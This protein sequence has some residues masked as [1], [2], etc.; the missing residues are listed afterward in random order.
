MSSLRGFSIFVE[1]YCYTTKVT[2]LIIW[3]SSF[4]LVK[5]CNC[6][7]CLTLEYVFLPAVSS[8]CLCLF[9]P[10][11]WWLAWAPSFF[12][13]RPSTCI[14]SMHHRISFIPFN[15]WIIFHCVDI[16]GSHLIC[17]SGAGYYG[18]FEFVT[19]VDKAA[20]YPCERVLDGRAV[21]TGVGTMDSH[22]N[23][24]CNI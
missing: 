5:M 13:Y 6:F 23:S 4:L 18:C 21:S 15:G 8:H 16:L 12:L 1:T 9:P 2:H 17:S 20:V 11:H 19:I 3:C 24:L 14:V 22:R 10:Q 7:H